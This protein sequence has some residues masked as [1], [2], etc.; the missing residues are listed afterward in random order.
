MADMKKEKF[1][2]HVTLFSRLTAKNNMK[3]NRDNNRAAHSGLLL[4]ASCR[5]VL[6]PHF[7]LFL[8]SGNQLV[9]VSKSAGWFC[10]IFAPGIVYCLWLLK[11]LSWLYSQ[12]WVPNRI[13]HAIVCNDDLS[14]S[15]TSW[16]SYIYRSPT[17]SAC[18]KKG[19]FLSILF[20]Y[21]LQTFSAYTTY[22]VSPIILHLSI[23]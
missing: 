1:M 7:F 19:S 23:P 20:S 10:I 5:G 8:S 16:I 6:P 22:L 12:V 2:Y 15:M 11:P 21:F 17:H 14:I 13:L 9:C 18:K 4:S 3:F